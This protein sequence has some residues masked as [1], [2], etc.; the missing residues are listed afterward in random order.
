[1]S[2]NTLLIHDTRTVGVITATVLARVLRRTQGAEIHALFGRDITS[3]TSKFWGQART[4]IEAELRQRA[5]GRIILCCVGFDDRNK[6]ECQKTIEW[7]Q[8]KTTKLDIYS[9]KW[10]DGY[11]RAGFD[12]LVS[13]QAILEEFGGNLEPE[14]WNLLR[15]S[16][17]VAR[18]TDRE[19]ATEADIQLADH[20]AKNIWPTHADPK[21]RRVLEKQRWNTLLDDLVKDITESEGNEP[22]ITIDRGSPGCVVFD[23]QEEEPP[24]SIT[25]TLEIEADQDKFPNPGIAIGLVNWSSN[26][27]RA[28][29]LRPW[30]QRKNLPSIAHLVESYGKNLEPDRWVGT[31]DAMH[32]RLSRSKRSDNDL[33]E[34]LPGRL[35]EFCRKEGGR[36]FGAR[37][38]HP[39]AAQ[40]IYKQ[41]TEILGK[42]DLFRQFV[43]ADDP[44]NSELN[45]DPEG[46]QI[47][48]SQ[49]NRSNDL[50]A[51][52]LALRLVVK[53]PAAAAFLFGHGGY[54]FTKLETSLEGAQAAISR[55]P[56]LWLGAITVPSKLRIDAEL[57]DLRQIGEAFSVLKEIAWL[58]VGEA[59]KSRVVGDRSVIARTLKETDSLI[60]FR[61]SETIGPSIQYA[62]LAY[63]V[64]AALRR[65]LGQKVEVLELFSGSGY[66]SRKLKESPD[67]A[68]MVCVDAAVNVETAGLTNA[69]DVVWLRTLIDQVLDPNGIYHHEYDVILMDP[70][71]G[72]LLDILFYGKA[73]G[74]SAVE[75]A[76]KLAPVLLIYVGHDSQ[77]ARSEAVARALRQW[78]ERVAEWRVGSERL[79]SAW[80][81]RPDGKKW[82]YDRFENEACVLAQ[83]EAGPVDAH[84]PVEIVR[85]F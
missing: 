80:R 21:R 69:Q 56:S 58:S 51:K 60:V 45:F 41:A 57:P 54:N 64:V 33:I 65:E 10:P 61:G 43:N 12:V 83:Q 25:K 62:T 17:I 27:P 55:I 37:Q 53:T 13:P 81:S 32:I 82:D 18:Q 2:N 38:P 29:L 85:K 28:H 84:W 31:Q 3:S 63:G 66:C 6:N 74:V 76:S 14:E 30:R 47:I 26:A 40:F 34:S 22:R 49:S 4:L 48:L 16:M 15:V 77:A 8:S 78:Y 35:R 70:P 46:I 79:I 36:L 1:M 24:V 5:Y 72:M 52:T 67:M 44:D 73:D 71:H 9:H 75:R 11:A 59:I 7:L 50:I 23:M 20:L 19:F 42:L 68:R 39:W